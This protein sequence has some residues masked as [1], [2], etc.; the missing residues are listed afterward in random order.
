ML[1]TR[2]QEIQVEQ[3]SDTSSAFIE[4]MR[5]EPITAALA[6]YC[7]L[8]VWFTVGL[9]LYHT[10]LIGTNQ[11]TYEH[12]KGLYSVGANPFHRGGPISNCQDVLCSP[13]RRRYFDGRTGEM[14]WPAA[15]R[16]S[17]R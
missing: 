2:G 17:V 9:C 14:Q 8:L 10:Y 3:S 16:D 5:Q 13:V 11:T 12:I 4:T 7:T 6:I 15:K 1:A